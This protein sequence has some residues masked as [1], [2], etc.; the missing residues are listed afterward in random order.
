MAEGEFPKQIGI[1]KRAVA[2]DERAVQAWINERLS[3]SVKAKEV[4][5]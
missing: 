1:S 3:S 5:K 2:W 4:A